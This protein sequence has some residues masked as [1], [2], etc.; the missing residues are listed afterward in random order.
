MLLIIVLLAAILTPKAIWFILPITVCLVRAVGWRATWTA[1]AFSDLMIG[2]PLALIMS[3]RGY[4]D[5]WI[6]ANL[7]WRGVIYVLGVSLVLR[8]TWGRPLPDAILP[9]RGR[10][11]RRAGAALGLGCVLGVGPAGSLMELYA[12]RWPRSWDTNPEW[13]LLPA[14]FLVYAATLWPMLAGERPRRLPP[15]KPQPRSEADLT[16]LR[17]TAGSQD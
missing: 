14:L 10:W 12:R 9:L 3:T 4:T 8:L 13:L 5:E 17:R 2:T 11:A 15:V 16:I 1:Y 6:W 7:P